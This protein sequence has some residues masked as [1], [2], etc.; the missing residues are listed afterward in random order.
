MAGK[1]NP[2]RARTALLVAS[3]LAWILILTEPGGGAW[4]AH[5]P[6]VAS[7]AMPFAASFRMLLTMNS[8]MS[9]AAGWSLMLVAMM[10]PAMIAPVLHVRLRSFRRRRGRATALFLAAYGAVWMTAGLILLSI[11]LAAA[12]FAPQSFWPATIAAAVAILWQC[13]PLKQRCLNRGHLHPEIRAFGSAAD[14]DTIRFGVTHGF[15]C[16]AS[17]WA[18]MLAPML[19]PRWHILA[20]AMVSVLMLGEWLEHPAP[21]AWQWRGISRLKRMAVEQ[22]RFRLSQSFP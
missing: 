13:S 19:L 10:A 17:C 4:F 3:A 22:T 8:A 11:E 12:S 14:L 15:W 16:V 9:L 1:G 5:C 18:M 21:P 2:A 7:G 20:M 6:A